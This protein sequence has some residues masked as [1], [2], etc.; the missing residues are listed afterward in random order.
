MAGRIP[1]LEAEWV[2]RGETHRHQ[3]ESES[4]FLTPSAQCLRGAWV[5][6][7]VRQP[8]FLPHPPSGVE[9]ARPARKIVTVVSAGLL[10]SGIIAA[11]PAIAGLQLKTQ[12]AITAVLVLGLAALLLRQPRKALLVG[13]ILAVTYNR[14]YFSF[15]GVF[16][17]HGVHGFYWIPADILLLGLC[18]VA[19]FEAI[20]AKALPAAV[21]GPFGLAQSS[22]RP[23]LWLLPFLFV[24][25]L[26]A[27]A[28]FTPEWS[29]FEWLRLV[30]TALLLLILNRLLK[31]GDWWLCI[32]A[33][34]FSILAQG[35]LG[36]MQTSMNA[37]TGLLTMLG[38][39]GPQAETT[40]F[41]LGGQAQT[42]AAGTM[43]HPNIL[44]PYLLFLLPVFMALA[45]DRRPPALMGRLAALAA[46]F[47]GLGLVSTMSRLPIALVLMEAGAIGAV[48]VW[49]GL[50]S[51]TR[52]LFIAC[53]AGLLVGLASMAMLDRIQE[54]LFTDLEASV[55]F[56]TRYNDVA[57]T[58]WE[59][60]PLLG[61]GLNNFTIRLK[62]LAP[63]LGAI[64][65]EMGESSRKV[66]LRT[67]APVHNVYWL[68]LAESGF[69]GLS[70]FLVFLAGPLVLGIRRLRD[71]GGR[72]R[73]VVFGLLVGLC[74][75][76]VQQFM[77]FS[78]WMDPGLNT[79]ALIFA[80]ISTAPRST[81]IRAHA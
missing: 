13:W 2:E 32:A 5:P 12:I 76:Y 56:R 43:S 28:A 71:T 17:D 62:A 4:V 23:V 77:D 63:D 47:G 46:A 48:M 33:L 54:R 21:A 10:S 64:I 7:D 50:V 14:Q 45:L 52:G 65:D 75:Q 80:L 44:G 70:A 8:D 53:V 24:G 58:M 25:L 20:H 6:N 22:G 61:V 55:D 79:F 51:A 9:A 41:S 49:M 16:G 59:D 69:L 11:A 72:V 1:R 19:A 42:R 66:G 68:V 34:G 67:I 81:E 31:P 36:V 29:L 39:S 30:K 15:D 27:G 74:A 57:R 38:G 26:S 40:T 60:S 37:G 18:L 35:G 78:L 3:A 73:L